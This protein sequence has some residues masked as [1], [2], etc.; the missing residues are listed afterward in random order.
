MP[1]TYP[2]LKNEHGWAKYCF[3]EDSLEEPHLPLLTLMI[4]LDEV[5]ILRLLK[6]HIKW[7]QSTPSTSSSLRLQWLFALLVCLDLPIDASMQA[8]LFQLQ[9]TC[10]TIRATSEI[11]EDEA[12][13]GLNTVITV[14]ERIFGQKDV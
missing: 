2:D 6:L 1:T 10:K 11:L 5:A 3:G 7:Y 4:Q 9:K 12:L 13:A 14:L 8:E